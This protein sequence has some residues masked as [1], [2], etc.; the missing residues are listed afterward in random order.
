MVLED[1]LR[2]WQQMIGVGL[3]IILVYIVGLLVGN[4]IGR[5]G[6]R[7]AELGVMRIPFIRAIYPAAK[8]ITDFVLS[9]RK[10][11]V[12]S[13]RVV[14]VHARDPNVWSIGLVTGSGLRPLSEQLGDEMITV[15]VPSTPTAFSGYVVVVARESVVE[16]PMTVEEAMRLL[17]S[18]GVIAPGARGLPG[19]S[20]TPGGSGVAG[21]SRETPAGPGRTEPEG[22]RRVA[23]ELV[24]APAAVELKELKELNE[25]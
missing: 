13:S 15:F 2:G 3:A 23:G 22:E 4:F 5:T 12:L 17:V 8:Q 10:T 18:G 16:L 19:G 24:P 25:P 9:D 21:S 6:W 7:L 14:A 1:H 20:G 11:Q